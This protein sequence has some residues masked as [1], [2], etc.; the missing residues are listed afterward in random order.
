MT[1][2]APDLADFGL[3][4]AFQNQRARPHTVSISLSVNPASPRT[5]RVCSPSRGTCE[6][7]TGGVSDILI[8]DPRVGIRPRVG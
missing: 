4:A 6:P 1:R 5:S 3:A 8:G 7:T 2:G